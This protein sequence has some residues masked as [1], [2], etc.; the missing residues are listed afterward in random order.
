MNNLDAIVQVVSC[1]DNRIEGRIRLQ[2]LIYLLQHLGVPFSEK[3]TY[4]HFGP[5]SHD[6]QYEVEELKRYGLLSEEG[7]PPS[8][9]YYYSLGPKAEEL[10]ARL[11]PAERRKIDKAV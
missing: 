7:G 4:L 2:K 10:L 6:L 3:Y 5:F 1:H 9:P 11:T 8:S